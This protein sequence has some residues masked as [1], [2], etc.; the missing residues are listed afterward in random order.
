MAANFIEFNGH[1]Q[2]VIIRISSI[3]SIADSGKTCYLRL[4]GESTGHTLYHSYQN[5]KEA[6]VSAATFGDDLYSLIDAE[7]GKYIS[8]LN[9]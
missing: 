1:N 3:G 7:A 2:K 6:I 5:I 8:R 4:L 9:R